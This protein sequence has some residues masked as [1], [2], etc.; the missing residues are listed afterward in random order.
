MKIFLISDSDYKIFAKVLSFGMFSHPDY[1]IFASE[2]DL[3]LS[4]YYAKIPCVYYIM[5]FKVV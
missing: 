4:S 2:A 3:V 5:F 1:K